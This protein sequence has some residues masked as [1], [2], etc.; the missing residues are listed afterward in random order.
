MAKSEDFLFFIK[1]QIYPYKSII[2]FILKAIVIYF[3]LKYIF[4]GYVGLVDD[5]G[6]YHSPFLA[7]YSLIQLLVEIIAWPTRGILVL[8]GYDTFAYLNVV[9]IEGAAGVRILFPCL[10]VEMMIAWFALIF[11]Y[12]SKTAK[13]KAIFLGIAGIFVINIIRVLYLLL[14]QYHNPGV[15]LIRTHDI[16]NNVVYVFIFI[17]FMLYLRHVGKKEEE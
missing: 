8:L 16:F 15:K 13:W 12:P 17:A 11:S 2:I 6:G 3:I 1:A 7:R 10:G 5:G 9:G 14:T 4:L